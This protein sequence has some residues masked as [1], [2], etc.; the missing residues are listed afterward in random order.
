MKFVF[1][2]LSHNDVD[3]CAHGHTGV[4][5]EEAEPGLLDAPQVARLADKV[6]HVAHRCG[7]GVA[8]RRG[9]VHRRPTDVQKVGPQTA[10]RELGDRSEHLGRHGRHQEPA[11]AN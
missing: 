1:F 6:L 10:Q 7:K 3:G 8:K 9:Q 4:A 2:L 5:G 11:F